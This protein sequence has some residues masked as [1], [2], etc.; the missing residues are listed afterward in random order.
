VGLDDLLA[1]DIAAVDEVVDCL[2]LDFLDALAVEDPAAFDLLRA[3]GAVLASAGLDLGPPLAPATD[4]AVATD[5][6]DIA[7]RFE[8]IVG[9]GAL[10]FLRTPMAVWC[11]GLPVGA[12]LSAAA[13][14]STGQRRAGSTGW[15]AAPPICGW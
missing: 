8:A 7:A 13:T 3:Y 4:V 12:V 10:A 15:S 1:F 5:P 14:L 11:Q 9:E 2:D 6:T